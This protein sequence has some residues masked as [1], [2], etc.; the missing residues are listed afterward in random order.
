M[1]TRPDRASRLAASW[2]GIV[3]AATAVAV[4][5]PVLSMGRLRTF[6]DGVYGLSVLAMR[7]GAA[8][9]RDVFS[10]QGPLFL[11]ML[12]VADVVGLRRLWAPRL[13]MVASGVGLAV[14]L[15]RLVS[16][17]L[18]PLPAMLVGV[19]VAL[20][21]SVFLAAGPLQSE[22]PTMALGAAA[23]VV[24][25]RDDPRWPRMAAAGLLV[26][27]AAATKNVF[28]VPAAVAVAVALW[29]SRGPGAV[30]A[31][32]GSAAATVVAVSLPFGLGA[33]W[34]QSV[35]F[36]LEGRRVPDVATHVGD[37]VGGLVRY[38][39]ALVGLVVAAVA[40]AVV[41]R[42]A[43]RT[44]VVV[45]VVWLATAAGMVAALGAG[46]GRG[47]YLVLVVPPAVLLVAAL[48]PPE[49][50]VAVVLAVL[51][52]VQ[53]AVSWGVVRGAQPDGTQARLVAF[54]EELP[55]GAS[56]VTDVPDLAYAAGRRAPAGAVDT[57]FAVVEAGRL[58]A[59]D[60]A[61]I[62]ADPDVCAVVQGS[63]RLA[64]VE[65]L[66]DVLADAGMVIGETFDGVRI[67]RRPSCGGAPR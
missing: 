13:A 49:R 61:G 20:G 38:E 56:A 51:A 25:E 44:D 14:A 66:E 10:S 45:A 48:R 46:H 63:G 24:A 2:G 54:L 29:R 34:D 53:L 40:A 17:R 7:H 9:F 50:L 31:A 39:P 55:E 12:W 3:V 35:T 26:G 64:R 47:R 43:Q 60:L 16:R 42:S 33:V 15:W 27:L 22:G 23:F 32:A 67:A 1:T 37:L 58:T 6:D 5:L 11:P 62:L 19:V 57:S 4:R 30:V 36:H 59:V 41:R 18:R 65:G 52:P 21:G 28:A 8:P